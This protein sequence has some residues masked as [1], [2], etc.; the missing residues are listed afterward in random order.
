MKNI[1]YITFILACLTFILSIKYLYN[2]YTS[3][4]TNPE[5]FLNNIVLVFSN[6]MVVLVFL[7]LGKSYVIINSNKIDEL[8]K[9]KLVIFILLIYIVFSFSVLMNFTLSFGFFDGEYLFNQIASILLSILLIGYFIYRL[10]V[11]NNGINNVA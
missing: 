7:F 10:K 3:T 4:P 11:V 5:N 2:S 9:A 8:K 1:K 6:I